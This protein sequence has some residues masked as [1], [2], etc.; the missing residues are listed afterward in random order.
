MSGRL[1]GKVAMSSAERQQRYRDKLRTARPALPPD[2]LTL[3]PEAIAARIFEAMPPEKAGRIATALSR[4]LTMWR[5]GTFDPAR[6]HIT[7]GA[8]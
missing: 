1:V 3:D 4:R 8:R 5:V 7:G 2:L 6:P